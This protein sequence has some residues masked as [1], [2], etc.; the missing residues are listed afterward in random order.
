MT[1]SEERRRWLGDELD[2]LEAEWRACEGN[3]VMSRISA[4]Q[5]SYRVFIGNHR[6]LKR[7]LAHIAEPQVA[8][9]MWEDGHRERI[10]QARWEALRL[11]HNYVASALSLVDVTR[12][13]MDKN[14]AGTAFLDDYQ[15]RIRDTFDEAQLHRFVQGLRVYT[16]HRRLPAMR[17]V[18]DLKP[19]ED[20][21]ANLDNYFELYVDELRKWKKWHSA[22]KRYLAKSDE[23]LRLSS[24]IDA[25]TP[26]VAEFHEWLAQRMG[27]EHA[28]ALEEL[29]D[30]ERRKWTIQQEWRA[31]WDEVHAERKQETGDP[32]SQDETVAASSDAAESDFATT[33][34]NLIATFYESISFSRGQQPNWDY[35]RALFVRDARIVEIKSD[36]TGMWNIDGYISDMRRSV[37]EGSLT[38]VSEV[39]I[40]RR[41]IPCGNIAHVISTYEAHFAGESGR[42]QVVRG[43]N[44]FHLAKAGNRWGI[45][46][47]HYHDE[48][49]QNPLPA[50]FLP[51]EPPEKLTE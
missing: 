23:K 13:F 21:G 43:I 35:L 31:A 20:G 36:G 26:V 3:H 44:S 33:V 34:D 29:F 22:A 19:R 12:R 42:S 1:V 51:G 40:V 46:S 5:N 50:E 11:F 7:Y 32:E 48:A 9:P 25:Y 15:E 17:V 14:Y 39:E 47:L 45:T 24:I 49:E 2:R 10:D 8:A 6:E 30:I 38:E 16:L 4:F 18:M 28:D 27:E 41:T 37:D